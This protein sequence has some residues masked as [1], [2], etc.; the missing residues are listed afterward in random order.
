[1]R[2]RGRPTARTLGRRV[3][4]IAAIALLAGACK[5]DGGGPVSANP[6]IAGRWTGS[7]KLGLVDFRADFTQSGDSVGGQGSFSSPLGGSDFAVAGVIKGGDVELVLTSATIGA[8]TF[9]G[10]FVAANRI[11]GPLDRPDADDLDLT[12]DRQ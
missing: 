10:R 2:P 11:E 3:V 12:L 7:A 4:G 9:R 6:S 1:M 8:T 5:G